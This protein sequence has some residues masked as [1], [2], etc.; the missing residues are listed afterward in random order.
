MYNQHLKREFERPGGADCDY[1]VKS[2]AIKEKFALS[3][4]WAYFP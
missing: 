4:F 1:S 2:L 3:N